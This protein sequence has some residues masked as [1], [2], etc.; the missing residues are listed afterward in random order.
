MYK[1]AMTYVCNAHH[2]FCAGLGV[3]KRGK[4]ENAHCAAWPV[5]GLQET[6]SGGG[7]AGVSLS[8]GIFHLYLA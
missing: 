8:G 1:Y 3:A 7:L 2:Y 5:A 4:E 6:A